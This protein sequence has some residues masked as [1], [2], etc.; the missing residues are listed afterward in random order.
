MRGAEEDYYTAKY[1]MSNQHSTVRARITYEYTVDENFV[2]TLKPVVCECQRKSPFFISNHL[3]NMKPR[4]SVLV[5]L[6]VL[7]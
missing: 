2:R 1:F 5:V 3:D 6:P 4:S 7:V